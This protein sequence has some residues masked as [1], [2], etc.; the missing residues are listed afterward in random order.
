MSDQVR[1]IRLQVAG[2]ELSEKLSERLDKVN[3]TFLLKDLEAGGVTS[4]RDLTYWACLVTQPDFLQI[5]QEAIGLERTE[6]HKTNLAA[7]EHLLFV[8]RVEESERCW[9]GEQGELF[10]S[11]CWLF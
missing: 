8:L 9:P 2:P 10:C 6:H 1:Y 4:L 5:T 3:G 11:L 7:W